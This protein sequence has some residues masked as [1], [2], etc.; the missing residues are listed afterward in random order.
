MAL[1]LLLQSCASTEKIKVPEIT[2]PEF[3]ALPENVVVED[4]FVTVPESYMIDL[5]VYRIKIGETEK[6]YKGLKELYKR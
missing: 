6:L 4:G 3:P 1:T 2:F 5:A